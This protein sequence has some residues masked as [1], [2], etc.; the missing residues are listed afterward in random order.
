MPRKK[1]STRQKKARKKKAARKAY[2]AT[3]H[4]TFEA[5][6][7]SNVYAARRR[8]KENGLACDIEE[9]DFVF[10]SHCKLLPEREFKHDGTREDKDNS[11]SIDRLDPGKGYIKS[12]VWL[13]CSRAN[14][15]KNNATYEEFETIYFN[16]RAELIRRGELKP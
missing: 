8:A 11:L 5:R 3:R 2:L 16:W 1:L 10:Q 13:I 14:R 12:N 15:I 6:I 7:R 9:E 4:G